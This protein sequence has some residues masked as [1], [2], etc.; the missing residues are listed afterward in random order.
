VVK[1]I[2]II[3]ACLILISGLIAY[4]FMKFSSSPVV[5]DVQSENNYEYTADNYER[6]LNNYEQTLQEKN[7]SM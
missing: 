2:A 3:I 7:E 5:E 4:D 1:V 6:T